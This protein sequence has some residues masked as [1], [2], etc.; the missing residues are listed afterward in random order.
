[1]CL[2]LASKKPSER[3]FFVPAKTDLGVK[4][5]T[6]TQAYGVCESP[7]YSSQIPVVRKN[8]LCWD[9]NSGGGSVKMRLPCPISRHLPLSW[10]PP[11]TIV[12]RPLCRCCSST[13]SCQPPSFSACPVSLSAKMKLCI[14]CFVQR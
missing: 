14:I 10:R 1:M 8:K 13:A 12:A 7:T 5:L 9:S 3:Q 6:K 4:L 2:C 11:W